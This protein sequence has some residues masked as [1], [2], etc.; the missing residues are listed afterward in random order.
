[1]RAPAA[2]LTTSPA[3]WRPPMPSDRK[4]DYDV[5]YGKPP[6]H[7]RFAKGQSGNPRG[8]SSGA[9]NFTTLLRETLNEIAIVTDKGGSRNV[10]KRQATITQLVHRSPTPA[11]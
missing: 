5:G 10:S 11:F 4:G 6:R 9:K 8:R 3:R 2:A 1:M 7:T